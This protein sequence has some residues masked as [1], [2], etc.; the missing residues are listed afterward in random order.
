MK[1][2]REIWIGLK[3]CDILQEKVTYVGKCNFA[4]ERKIA[5]NFKK[6]KFQILKNTCSRY[7]WESCIPSK[8]S[9]WFDSV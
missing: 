7:V 2:S 6:V 9:I 1:E 8:N 5:G 4:E 3:I